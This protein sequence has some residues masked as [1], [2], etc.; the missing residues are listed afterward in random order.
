[1]SSSASKVSL[2]I[3]LA[4]DPK[5]PYKLLSVPEDTPF[6]HVLRFAC[7]EFKVP[8]D[9]SAILTKEGVGVNPNQTA[10]AIFLKHGS[11]L[12]LI[13][14]DRVGSSLGEF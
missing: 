3:T 4:S 8:A 10:G 13:P 14:R 9:S 1:M 12:S 11:E 6:I 2:K 7:N 5:L